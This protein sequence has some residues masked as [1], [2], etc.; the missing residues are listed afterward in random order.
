MRSVEEEV[1]NAHLSEKMWLCFGYWVIRLE[2]LVE[3]E[4]DESLRI[5]EGT[6]NPFYCFKK[7]RLKLSFA[8]REIWRLFYTTTK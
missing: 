8:W 6:K 5:K 3:E 7:R 1:E 2:A 4:E